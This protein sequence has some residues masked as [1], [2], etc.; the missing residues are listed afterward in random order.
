[1]WRCRIGTSFRGAPIAI[2]AAATFEIAISAVTASWARPRLCGLLLHSQHKFQDLRTPIPN[3]DCSGH[4]RR[5]RLGT[6]FAERS[7]SDNLSK[8]GNS[9]LN[10]KPNA[11]IVSNWLLN[12]PT[13][14]QMPFPLA[15]KLTPPHLAAEEMEVFA[16]HPV[17]FCPKQASLA[18]K[19]EP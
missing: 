13:S 11:G 2:V 16:A 5:E 8:K 12:A 14:R 17:S 18:N 3:M 10:E 9:G 4:Y 7:Q 6:L 1:M 15:S 19:C